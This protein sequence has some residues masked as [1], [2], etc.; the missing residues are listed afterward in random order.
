M[1]L[2]EADRIPLRRRDIKNYSRRLAPVIQLSLSHQ[3]SLLLF[4]PRSWRLDDWSSF[5]QKE[6]KMNAALG[7]WEE[8]FSR[9][10][11][12]VGFFPI[13]EIFLKLLIEEA[14]VPIYVR[15]D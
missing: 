1:L 10:F 4:P 15:R 14:T 7:G 9:K 8:W 6:Y 13:F 3:V 12:R 11:D 2:N 5:D